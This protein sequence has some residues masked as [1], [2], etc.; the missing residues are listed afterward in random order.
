MKDLSL[1]NILGSSFGIFEINV[2][3]VI[4]GQNWFRYYYASNIIRVD[5]Y[6]CDKL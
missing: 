6:I 4:L 3:K 5:Y 1:F 2:T